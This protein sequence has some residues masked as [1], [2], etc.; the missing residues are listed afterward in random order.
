[1]NDSNQIANEAALAELAEAA[2][3]GRLAVLFGAGA[4][5]ESFKALPEGLS[6]LGSW[7]G[8]LDLLRQAAQSEPNPFIDDLAQAEQNIQR[9]R[10]D[11]QVDLLDVAS[12]LREATSDAWVRDQII[13]LFNKA[14][15][16]GAG[17]SPIHIA[18][19]SLS[20]TTF[21]TTNYDPYFERACLAQRGAPCQIALPQDLTSLASIGTGWLCKLHGDLLRPGSIVLSV[22]DFDRLSYEVPPAWKH[23]FRAYL[24][25]SGKL[26]LVG[27]GYGDP[28]I[29]AVVDELRGAYQGNLTSAY[30]LGKVDRTTERRAR[31]K[32]IRFIGVPDYG[33]ILPWLERLRLAIERRRQQELPPVVAIQLSAYARAVAGTTSEALERA[34]AALATGHFSEAESQLRLLTHRTKDVVA[35][36]PLQ[37]PLHLHATLLLAGSLLCQQE[38]E[39]ARPLFQEMASALQQDP[40]LL[41]DEARGLLAQGLVQIREIPSARA[42]L[43]ADDSEATAMARQLLALHDG[44]PLDREVVKPFVE[45]Q[46][47]GHM[48][49]EGRLADAVTQV[50]RFLPGADLFCQ[51][52]ALGV[53]YAALNR[54]IFDDPIQPVPPAQR[55]AVVEAIESLI[56]GIYSHDPPLPRR[57]RE[58]LLRLSIRFY[59]LV[60]DAARTRRAEAALANEGYPPE[61]PRETRSAPLSPDERASATGRGTDRAWLGRL[62]M[63]EASATENPSQALVDTLALCAEHSQRAPVRYF[64]V[65]QLLVARRSAEALVHA[66]AAVQALPGWGYRF[67]LAQCLLKTGRGQEAWAELQR[68]EAL[69]ARGPRWPEVGHD[70]SEHALLQTRAAAAEMG[71]PDQ[72]PELWR[73]YLSSSPDDAPVAHLQLARALQRLGHPAAEV[74]REAW[75]AV[76]LDQVAH[77][78]SPHQLYY[79]AQLMR[80]SGLLQQRDKERLREIAGQLKTRFPDDG[81]AERYRFQILVALGEVTA[82]QLDL[83]LLEK[84]GLAKRLPIEEMEARIQTENDMRQE[85]ARLY[86]AGEISFL[87]LCHLTSEE[88]AA[89]LNHL[90]SGPKQEPAAP[91]LCPPI[92]IYVEAAPPPPPVLSGKETL[93]GHL[94]LLLLSHL[95]LLVPLGEA[96]HAGGGK[97][98]CFTDTLDAIEQGARRLRERT[99]PEEMRKLGELEVLLRRYVAVGKLNLSG[100]LPGG[101]ADEVLAMMAGDAVIHE[102]RHAQ[103]AVWLSPRALVAHLHEQLGVIDRQQ[104]A[105][106]LGSLP[107]GE[108]PLPKPLPK[109]VHITFVSLYAF[110]HFDALAALISALPGQ[111]IVGPKT[112]WLL[113]SRRQEL[114]QADN[115]ARMA[116]K[117]RDEVG[118]GLRAGWLAPLPQPDPG[119]I[120]AA[121]SDS[122]SRTAREALWLALRPRLALMAQSD[123]YLLNAE[124]NVSAPYAGRVMRGYV[125]NLPW[126]T[127]QSF[128]DFAEQ[129]RGVSK[130][131]LPLP[132]VVFALN[133][134]RLRD[135]LIALGFVDALRARDLLEYARRYRGLDRVAP[136][137]LLDD[138][139]WR[140]HKPNHPAGN[141]LRHRLS[142][143]Y[144]GAIWEAFCGDAGPLP[145]RDGVAQVLLQRAE[146]ID[147]GTANGML[148]ALLEVV[149]RRALVFQQASFEAADADTM[150][151]SDDAPAGAFWRFLRGWAADDRRR[152]AA[153]AHAIRQG[154]L[155]VDG[156]ARMPGKESWARLMTP[157]LLA[158]QQVRTRKQAVT[159][160]L[161]AE[162]QPPPRGLLP[163][164]IPDRNALQVA[165]TGSLLVPEREALAILSALWSP[166]QRAAV[167]DGV[168]LRPPRASASIKLSYEAVLQRGAAL[169]SAA[170]M[171]PS[172]SEVGG[173]WYGQISMPGGD[174]LSVWFPPEALLLRT[175]EGTLRTWARSLAIHQGCHDGRAYTL[176][177][178]L[179]ER[180]DDLAL[181]REY[182]RA[183][184]Q[185]PFRQVR[186]DP[187]CIRSWV[188]SAW[189]GSRFP[190]SLADL[191][192]MLSE[193]DEPMPDQPMSQI[194]FER[195]ETGVWKSRDDRVPLGRQ[196][197]LVPG[198][199]PVLDLAWRLSQEEYASEVA[200]AINRLEHSTEWCAATLCGDMFLLRGAL[201]HQPLVRI[202]E[203]EVDLRQR[204]PGV[205]SGLLQTVIAV[206]MAPP[207]RTG[208][209]AETEA[210]ILRLCS[211]I[212]QGLAASSDEV[213]LVSDGLWLTYR[214]FQWL[215]AQL[216]ATPPAARLSAQLALSN[217]APEHLP[218]ENCSQDLLDPARFS[219]RFDH[220]LAAVLHALVKME[221]LPDV[222][223]GDQT[224]LPEEPRCSVS[225]PEIEKLLVELTRRAL[226]PED[227]LRRQR[228]ARPFNAT[229]KPPLPRPSFLGWLG[230]VTIPELALHALLTLQLEAFFELSTEE[231]LRWLTGLPPTPEAN[232][233]VDL[234]LVGPLLSAAISFSGRLTTAERVLLKERGLGLLDAGLPPHWPQLASTLESLCFQ[235]LLELYAGGE[236][237]LF[238]CIQK[239]FLTQLDT[240]LAVSLCASYFAALA[241]VAPDMLELEVA[242]ILQTARDPLPFARG[243]CG[244]LLGDNQ[245]GRRI[246]ERIL[247]RLAQTPPFRDDDLM[248]QQLARLGIPRSMT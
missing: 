62:R 190:A 188:G 92:P 82:A 71:A 242:R 221:G 174:A 160:I 226:L 175:T 89:Y 87:A 80:G 7:V 122:S 134:D 99:Q 159:V 186:E 2:G 111:V 163:E 182:A 17:P 165:F 234:A 126:P 58:D 151:A 139:E 13:R 131:E 152:R 90:I 79:V 50:L 209:V 86:Q 5:R 222:N 43:P 61:L 204:L 232:Q 210:G 136:R 56:G 149:V 81:Q 231:R 144:A 52:T 243:L 216:Q 113:S 224:G 75:Q 223:R 57:M 76:M 102:E 8:L 184:V 66:E 3:K 244:M 228:F 142:E 127:A 185:A 148:D 72:E 38:V 16:L 218:E 47:C 201:E 128:P 157:L 117:L 215:D 64:A 121:R 166:E 187:T 203:G 93:T 145:E 45:M 74:S 60:A 196:A 143:L 73:R 130:R 53:L 154:W 59:N 172:L 83:D 88:P 115:S 147:R 98:R 55:P 198:T 205:L 41:S 100:T 94:E 14:D 212:V 85:A 235:L 164:E 240:Q 238:S 247:R 107:P 78:L 112:A 241:R 44:A 34:A 150:R 189:R 49:Q 114:R 246:A 32:G 106:L 248:R 155:I 156:V 217:L 146:L 21:F 179:I 119:A 230:P 138:L 105:D 213:L 26:L 27:Y 9:A 68:M 19:A 214:L 97:L 48:V 95:D 195:I 133:G 124:F 162:G 180:P 181:R 153:C 104:A 129:L 37:R 227:E 170:A 1:M 63:I 110:F 200:L 229:L 197:C 202:S 11:E 161:A 192:Q 54:T 178:R 10:N 91:F 173:M 77:S 4:S 101:H 225:S 120:P 103:G 6:S 35:V 108:E 118:A 191:R 140:A 18:L 194:L 245:E 31:N 33:S 84:A 220:R 236:T 96:V 12:I 167:D 40:T 206:S 28:D 24:Q 36:D 137:Q 69:R 46:R 125:S 193:P 208:S 30:W 177:H 219:D 15:S 207:A 158:M 176:L 183:M 199:L 171:S 233:A 132:H 169:M 29:V 141:M 168:E 135:R 237:D 70:E 51:G 42:I 25:A 211:W 67:F 239:P 39:K 22:Q 23:L 123:L 20:G 65:Y 109:R 116:E